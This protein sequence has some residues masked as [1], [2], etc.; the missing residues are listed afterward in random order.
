MMQATV[1][2]RPPANKQAD[3][4]STLPVLRCTEVSQQTD[5]AT[6]QPKGITPDLARGLGRRL[7]IPVELGMASSASPVIKRLAGLPRIMSG[8]YRNAAIR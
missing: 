7:G 8:G 2:T 1:V 4:R 6:G 5:A 3:P